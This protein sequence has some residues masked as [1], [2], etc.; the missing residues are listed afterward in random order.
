LESLELRNVIGLSVVQ[1]VVQPRAKD[2][3]HSKRAKPAGGQMGELPSNQLLGVPVADPHLLVKGEGDR[4]AGGVKLR[5]CFA[6][7]KNRSR[8]R[9]FCE[10]KE[11]VEE[12]VGGRVEELVL[13]RRER[14]IPPRG[15]RAVNLKRGQAVQG[16]VG[17]RVVDEG[18]Q[19]EVRI[20]CFEGFRTRC[21]DHRPEKSLNAPVQPFDHPV[22]FGPPRHRHPMVNAQPP[23]P[24]GEE[25]R[26]ELR[27]PVRHELLGQPVDEEDLVEQ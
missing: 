4:E 27:I 20:P 3:D 21:A 19:G 10:E 12:G 18:H 2:V 11:A 22:A 24:G 13:E 9:L 8:S 17:G 16:R 25:G 15:P 23:T 14:S 7:S 1:S 6:L 26:R 5:F